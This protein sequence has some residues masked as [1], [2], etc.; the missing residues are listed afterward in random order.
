MKKALFFLVLPLFLVSILSAQSLA[1]LS[2]KEK[3]RRESLKGKRAILITN[4]DLG[5]TKKK[6]GIETPP[7]QPQPQTEGQPAPEAEQPSDY[8]PSEGEPNPEGMSQAEESGET[9]QMAD[10]FRT[11][12]EAK[13]A[14]VKEYADLLE[15]KMTV[16]WQEFYS[17]DDMTSRDSIQQ[18]IALTFDKLGKA[19]EDENSVKKELDDY[20]ARIGKEGAQ[21]K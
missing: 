1:E 10:G 7:P 2:K 21:R 19:R 4:A 14:Q 15:L 17:M 5:K 13:Y 6:A 20:I 8:V 12:L 18:E 16:L 11:S 3:E 9:R